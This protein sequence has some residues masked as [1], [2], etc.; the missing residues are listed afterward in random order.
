MIFSQKTKYGIQATLYTALQKDE[1]TFS[2]RRISDEMGISYSY[3]AKIVKELS[4][5]DILNTVR[6]KG[7]GLQL[8]KK[9]KNIKLIDIL[10]ALE[11]DDYFDTCILGKKTCR[12]KD[13]CICTYTWRQIQQ[14]I[15]MFL[16][17]STLEDLTSIDQLSHTR[18]SDKL[19]CAV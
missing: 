8:A 15:Y 9:P 18:L 5:S 19:T 11:G 13:G 1:K 10:Y 4:Q 16:S 7:G 14:E 2:T 6:G 12:T 17:E 3:L